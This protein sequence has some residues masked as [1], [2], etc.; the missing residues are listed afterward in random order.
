MIT[1]VEGSNSVGFDLEK[2]PMI[3]REIENGFIIMNRE[4][5]ERTWAYPIHNIARMAIDPQEQTE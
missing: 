5:E 1:N 4:A 2:E 3:I